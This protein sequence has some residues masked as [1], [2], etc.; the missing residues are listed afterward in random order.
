VRNAGG[1]HWRFDC[2]REAFSQHDEADPQARK[3]LAAW[4]SD[5]SAVADGEPIAEQPFDA[6]EVTAA[7][8]KDGW[9]AVDADG[10]VRVSVPLPG[11]FRQI[12]LHGPRLQCELL[13]LEGTEDEC[14]RAALHLAA[15]AND[16]LRLARFALLPP[17]RLVAGVHLGSLGVSGAWLGGALEALRAAVAMTAREFAALRGDRELAGLVLAAAAA[18]KEGVSCPPQ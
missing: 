8:E 17:G 9:P 18:G 15:V 6:A 2:P 16:R 7:L 3:P 11:L 1:G 10:G 13:D 5:L 12:T 4:V 14:R